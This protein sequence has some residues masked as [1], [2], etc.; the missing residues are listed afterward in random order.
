VPKHVKKDEK[1]EELKQPEKKKKKVGYTESLSIILKSRHLLFL[2][3]I[4]ITSIVVATIVDFQFNWIVETS[5]PELD[6]R[7]AFFGIFYTGLLVFSYLLHIFSTNMILKKFGIRTAL[8]V[9]PLVLFTGSIGLILIPVLACAIFLKGTDRSLAHSLNQ[10]VREL[11]YIP[12]SPEVKYKA[13]VFIDMFLSKFAKGIAAIL[14]VIFLSYLHFSERQISVIALVFIALWIAFSLLITKEYVNVVKKNLRIKWQDADDVISDKIDVDMTKMVFDTL[15]SKD[16]SSVL[17]AMNLFNLIEKEKMSPEVR[18]II[19]QRSDA[20]RAS[21]MDSLLGLDGESLLPELE[22]SLDKE[23]LSAQVKEIM[24]LDTYQEVM[25]K[26]LG[27]ITDK[28]SKTGETSRMEAA[29]GLGMMD[30]S[31]ALTDSLSKLL[32]DDSPDVLSC[33]IDSAG[34]LKRKDFVPLVISRLN[35]AAVHHDSCRSLIAYGDRILGTLKDYLSDPDESLRLRKSIPDIMAQ[36]GTQRAA[37][38]L[39]LELKK[40]SEVIAEEIIEAMYKMRS[41][42]PKLQFQETIINSEVMSQIKKS[43]QTLIEINDLLGSK[44][45]SELVSELERDLARSLKHIFEL[46]AL[47]YPRDDVN[48]AYQNISVGTKKA[49]DYSIELLDNILR[50]EIKEHLIPLIDDMPF[51]D[52]VKRCSQLLR[53]MEKD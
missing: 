11:L 16:R 53:A 45:K 29:K 3:G 40:R 8:L 35:T 14:L 33:A 48:R 2:S 15:Q 36:I 27:K 42:N 43:Y 34:K 32:R 28:K 50:R 46:L 5:Y 21:S 1:G 44:K 19:S 30:P 4:V 37:D 10:S 25:K 22:D 38:L 13:K 26:Q 52:K 51:E 7:T 20:V 47:I 49:I 39:S 9:A 18:K 31:S 24:S 41:K 17:Y 6:A 23:D 12:V